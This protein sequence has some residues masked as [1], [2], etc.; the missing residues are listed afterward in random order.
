MWVRDKGLASL[1]CP[2]LQWFYQFHIAGFLMGLGSNNKKTKWEFLA[3]ATKES[4]QESGTR[5]MMREN[6]CPLAAQVALQQ[7]QR[8]FYWGLRSS[9]SL[10]K[11]HSLEGAPGLVSCGCLI[12]ENATKSASVSVW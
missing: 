7:G 12:P 11:L 6:P 2:P 9:R 5:Q 8:L 1:P 10:W 3:R 4:S